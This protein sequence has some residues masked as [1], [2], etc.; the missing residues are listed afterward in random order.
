MIKKAKTLGVG[1]LLVTVGIFIGWSVTSTLSQSKEAVSTP[2]NVLHFKNTMGVVSFLSPLDID[3]DGTDELIY[4]ARSFSWHNLTYVL[5]ESYEGN[6]PFLLF[7]KSCSFRTHAS[8]PEFKDLN[9]D[10]KLDV[11]L[12]VTMDIETNEKSENVI[13]LYNGT[14]FVKQ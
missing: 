13:Y 2:S 4:E 12:P 9:S 7:C 5:K 14:D 1:L 10:G 11:L 8:S 6:A 3:S